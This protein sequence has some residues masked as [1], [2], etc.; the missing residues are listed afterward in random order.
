[1][2]SIE[3]RTG[4]RG[5]SYRVVWWTGQKPNRYKKSANFPTRK[6]AEDYA[7]LIE[8]AGGDQ[9]AADQAVL[10]QSSAAPHLS[11][12]AEA[13][14]SRLIDVSDFT[15]GQ[16]RRSARLHLSR[17]DMPVDQIT[18]DDIARWVSWMSKEA[19]DG[20]GYS[21]KTIKNAHG[22]LHSVLAFAV[23]RGHRSDNPA[24]ET[25]L[26]S[27]DQHD[28][29][30]KFLTREE[31]AALL[32]HVSERYRPH[33]VFLWGT[34]ARASEL[35]ALT[36][37]DF[38]VVDGVTFVSITKSVKMNE[39]GTGTTIGPPK[40]RRSRRRI[41]VDD[42]TMTWV[43]PLVRAAGH[44]QPVFPLMQPRTS[45]TLWKAMW[46]PAMDRA[47]AAG[48]T[49]RPK[50]H[51]LRHSHA[52]HLLAAGMPMHEVSRRLGHASLSI[53]DDVYAHIVPSRQAS[54]SLAMAGAVPAL[55]SSTAEIA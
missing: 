13:H 52:S 28:E 15:I 31:F 30:D 50:V 12:V 40:T 14:I 20:K 25:R 8:H 41:D 21:P 2:A 44:G 42:D 33:A 43:W 36:P 35:L 38:T 53:T 16:Y 9:A 17:L 3:T 46:K 54:A 24:A 1:M 51:S 7:K 4:K 29:R 32:P 47:R 23:K 34:G 26:P 18:D 27:A 11:E 5:T 19:R 45:S 55:A 48:F 6:A 10:S 37:E 49:K 39:S 22:L